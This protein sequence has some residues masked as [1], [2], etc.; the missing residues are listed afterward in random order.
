[1]KTRI[2]QSFDHAADT[3]DNAADLQKEVAHTLSTWLPAPPIKSIL[4]IGCG[5]GIFSEYLHKTYPNTPLL[6]TDIAPTM[7]ETCHKRMPKHRAEWIQY[8]CLDAEQLALN[9][10][11]DLITS[12]MTLHWFTDIQSG[13]QTILQH[14]ANK[15]RFIFSLPGSESLH[16]WHA[17]CKTHALPIGTPL[18]PSMTTLKKYFPNIQFFTEKKTQSFANLYTLLQ[19]FNL[20]G[21]TVPREDY[22]AISAG[23]L[24]RVLRQ[25][26]HPISVTY[27]VIYGVYDTHE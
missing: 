8:A 18:F 10:H 3:Y 17:I 1:M 22:K 7:L 11:F 14:V 5:T 4:E 19:H 13:I 9:N 23:A 26:Q 24:R 21:A 25:L 27:E 15:G 2:R 20:L 12:N 6:L 16:E